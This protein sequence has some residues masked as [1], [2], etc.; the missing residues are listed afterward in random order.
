[1][2][3]RTPS[4]RSLARRIRRPFFPATSCNWS[5]QR[6]PSLSLGSSQMTLG[7]ENS[8]AF[9]HKI[10]KCLPLWIKQLNEVA[11]LD[12]EVDCLEWQWFSK[13]RLSPCGYAHHGSMTV[14]QTITPE[15][16]CFLELLLN[17][18]KYKVISQ[19]AFLE[20]VKCPNFMEMG[21]VYSQVSMYI[22]MFHSMWA[23]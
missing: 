19:I 2:H 11:F 10:N 17:W 6:S 21:F 18:W 15:G 3:W 12:A 4:G 16:S 14:S 8:V 9:L 5:D 20:S 22:L 23:I 13:V 1:M 7:S